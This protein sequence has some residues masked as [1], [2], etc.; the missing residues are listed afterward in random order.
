MQQTKA[1][2]TFWITRQML[3]LFA[4]LGTMP[5]WAESVGLYQYLGVEI[6]I[7]MI[8]A[9]GFNLLLGYTGLPSFGHGAF[10]GLGAYAFGLVQHE[11]AVSLWLGLLG[12]VALAAAGG[13]L[14]ACFLSHRR[15][16]YFALMSIAFG[17]VFWFVAIKWHAVTGGEDGLLNIPRPAFDFGVG[18]LALDNNT[19]LFYFVLAVLAVVIIGLWRLVHSPFGKVIQ[20]VKQNE[21]RTAF[22]GYNVWLFKWSAFTISAAVA[23]LAGGLFAM[24]QESAYPDVMSLHASGF[25]VM[26]T[27]IGGGFVSFW[28]PVIGAAVFFLAR[29]LLGSMTETWLLWYGLMFMAVV[30]FKP[31]GIAGAWQ[32]MVKRRSS[33]RERGGHA[34]AALAAQL[35]R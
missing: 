30:V 26:M 16:I 28:G 20:A 2:P 14:V 33:G 3:V 27:L 15:G 24:A 13:G 9:L 12:A 11:L 23:G 5:L 31:E 18:H 6:V 17:Q 7:W 22:V 34:G 8:F 32:D 19:A 1:Q 25:V 10:F 4:V 29:D 21:M 35:K